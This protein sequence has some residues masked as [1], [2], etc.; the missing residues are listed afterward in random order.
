ML[1]GRTVNNIFGKDLYFRVKG[2]QESKRGPEIWI[3][4][5]TGTPWDNLCGVPLKRLFKN[6]GP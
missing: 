4:T 6:R 1:L 2:T 3:K 5:G